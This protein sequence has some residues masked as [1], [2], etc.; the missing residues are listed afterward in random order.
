MKA[1]D[2][3]V[4][5]DAAVTE[6]KWK[7]IQVYAE[8]N[9]KNGKVKSSSIV[10]KIENLNILKEDYRESLYNRLRYF[11]ITKEKFNNLI[12]RKIIKY[13]IK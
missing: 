12:T 11:E 6:H 2:I 13:D 8:Q 5:G 10:F 9:K 4:S 7:L 1:G 3:F